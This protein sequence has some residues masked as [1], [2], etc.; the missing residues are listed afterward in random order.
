MK[1]ILLF[2]SLFI[3]LFASNP[4]NHLDDKKYSQNVML[5]N[6]HFSKKEVKLL[7]KQLKIYEREQS[8]SLYL[9]LIKNHP[10]KSIEYDPIRLR[11]MNTHSRGEFTKYLLCNLIP[12]KKSEE[13][14]RI[15][16]LTINIATCLSKY[17]L[18]NY[19]NDISLKSLYDCVCFIEGYCFINTEYTDINSIYCT[20]KSRLRAHM[21]IYTPDIIKTIIEA[22]TPEINDTTHSD[23]QETSVS[24]LSTSASN[25]T[26]PKFSKHKTVTPPPP[27]I[28]NNQL[29]S[30]TK[31]KVLEDK[32]SVKSSTQLNDQES[33][34]KIKENKQEL[35]TKQR[36]LNVVTLQ[37]HSIEKK[38]ENLCYVIAKKILFD[39][40]LIISVGYAFVRFLSLILHYLH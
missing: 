28:P 20:L 27:F 23:S 4:N 13:F 6:Y 7:K 9:N 30:N 38:I 18:Q 39:T 34:T 19:N 11:F 25:N 2:A 15:Y 36:T 12:K 32:T 22:H 40:V 37:T 35:H 17:G 14:S 26:K 5:D 24:T 3:N 16:Y 8:K 29:S 31:S 1:K 21:N 33:K 10:N